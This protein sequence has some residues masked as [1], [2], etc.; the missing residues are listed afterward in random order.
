[1]L[2]RRLRLALVA[3]IVLQAL[4]F[5]HWPT[6]A[7]A[8]FAEICTSAG[9]VRLPGDVDPDPAPHDGGHC[10]LCRI[11][12]AIAGPPATAPAPPP[13]PSAERVA[14]ALLPPPAGQ[15]TAHDS[16]ARA[17]PQSA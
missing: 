7:A 6:A 3:L 1:M 14:V 17:P 9:I 16:P 13:R 11:A 8:N 2:G 12:E 10:P 4:P 15:P 5:A